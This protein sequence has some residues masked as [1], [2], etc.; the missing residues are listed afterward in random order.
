[1]DVRVLSCIVAAV[2]L[3]RP[4]RFASGGVALALRFVEIRLRRN[5]G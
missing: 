5:L 1:M 3:R 4:I 2:R